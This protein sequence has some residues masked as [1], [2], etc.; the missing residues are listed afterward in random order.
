MAYP[1]VAETSR[2]I[3]RAMYRVDE[4]MLSPYSYARREIG[5]L[6][7][8]GQRLRV[9]YDTLDEL[10]ILRREVASGREEGKTIHKDTGDEE[11][12]ANFATCLYRG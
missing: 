10:G 1:L 6:L 11:A 4:P 8:I 9:E 12:I 5:W 7:A 2:S 3:G